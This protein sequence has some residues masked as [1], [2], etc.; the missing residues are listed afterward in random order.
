M[1]IHDKKFI[2]VNLSAV[3]KGRNIYIYIHE[4]Y[5]DIL[6]QLLEKSIRDIMS[7]AQLY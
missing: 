1:I 7:H 3:Y 4:E 2:V 6:N 5:R